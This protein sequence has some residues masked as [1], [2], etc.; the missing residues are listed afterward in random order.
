MSLIVT[1]SIGIDTIETPQGKADDVVGGSSIYFAGAASFFTPVRLVGAVGED[2]PAEMEAMFTSFK[3][4]AVD[5]AGLE[6]RTGSKTFRWHGKY[7]E[8]MNIRDTLAVE[9]NV[10]IEDLP[11][12]PDHFKDSRYV[13]LACTAPSNQLQLLEQFPKRQLVVMD[14]IDLYIKQDAENL[15][16]VIAAVDGVIVNDDEAKLITGEQNVVIAG[17]KIVAMGPLFAVIKKGEHGAI[18][19][20]RDGSIAALPAFPADKVIDP[21]GAGDSFAGGM[22]GYLASQNAKSFDIETLKKAAGYGT[23][24]ASHTIEDFSVGRLQQI[25]RANLDTRLDQ[26]A[27]M[28]RIE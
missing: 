13:F 9:L 22:M 27:N 2:F 26:F 8:N 14:T 12:V 25:T 21:T 16:K 4:E 11:P 15:A 1:G 7:H 5:T 6:R 20:H 17:Q 19:F 24:V 3:G 23:A 28:V 10:L 18:V